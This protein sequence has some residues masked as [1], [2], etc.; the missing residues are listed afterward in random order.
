MS[1]IEATKTAAVHNK[2]KAEIVW[3]DS[4]KLEQKDKETWD[5]LKG[6]DG[7]IVPGG[8]GLR[9]IEGK[10]AAAK[11]ARTNKVPYLGLCLGSQIMAIEFARAKLKD[12]QLTSEEFDEESKVPKSKYVVNF[13]PGQHKGRAKGGTLRLGAYQCKLK[14]GTKAYQAYKDSGQLGDDDTISE[15]HRHRYE[16]NNNLRKKLEEK[17]LI[18]SGEWPETKLMEIVELKS[19]PFMLG[20]QFHPEFKSRPHR[21]QPL[22]NA[23]ME[24]VVG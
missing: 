5:D 14:K 15:R 16:F 9:G 13:L 19:H 20:S 2:R 24:A 11:H 17:G 4:E 12:P 8:F 21:P 1:V 3:I 18:F 22:F 7:I 23:F 10:I 6:C